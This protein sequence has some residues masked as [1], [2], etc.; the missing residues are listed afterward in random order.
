MGYLAFWLTVFAL[1]AGVLL[2]TWVVWIFWGTRIAWAGR[3]VGKRR[4]DTEPPETQAP[5]SNRR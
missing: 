2:A 1:A 3:Q 4:G 5:Y